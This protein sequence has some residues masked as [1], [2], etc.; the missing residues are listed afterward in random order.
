MAKKVWLGNLH[1]AQWVPAPA[2]G[3]VMRREGRSTELE[4]DNGGIWVDRSNAGHVVYEFDIPVSD[5][6]DYTGIEAYE[7]F[8]SGEYGSGFIYLSDP[9]IADQNVA[10]PN[11]AAPGLAEQG[12]KPIYDSTP[13][14]D[15]TD[16]NDYGMP[17]RKAT[18]ALPEAVDAVP[19]G[20]NSVLTVLI[21]EGHTLHIGAAG[22]VTGDGVLRV[23]P[24]EQDGTLDT[25]VDVAPTDETDPPEF[26]ESF[27]SADYRAVQVYLTRSGNSES[28]ITLAAIWIQV[29]PSG[30]TPVIDRHIPG[31][32]HTG[33]K[34]RGNTAG[35]TYVTATRHLIGASFQLVEVEQWQ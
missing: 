7:R 34:F 2:T 3:M 24:I 20:Q 21:P 13:G 17:L 26:T 19:T 16:P 5:A 32:G 27:D 1:H 11:W 29:L 33:M 14:F 18:Y 22:D 15:D 10:P 35:E 28:T 12:W 23:Q 8:H 30:Q 25:P 9:M 4:F 6:R 31:K